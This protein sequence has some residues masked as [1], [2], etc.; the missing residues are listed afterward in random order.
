MKK[1][2]YET[3]RVHFNTRVKA[4]LPTFV[5]GGL[6]RRKHGTGRPQVP[7]S[8]VILRTRTG[9]N[10]WKTSG[11]FPRVSTS[12][13]VTLRIASDGWRGITGRLQR[14]EHGTRRFQLP[15]AQVGERPISRYHTWR[16]AVQADHATV[17]CGATSIGGQDSTNEHRSAHRCEDPVSRKTGT[18]RWRPVSRARC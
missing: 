13:G 5:P 6:E 8:S 3:R 18:S 12:V 4:P 10:C 14:R 9:R 17:F 15:R 11:R 7:G 1:D 2:V 16:T